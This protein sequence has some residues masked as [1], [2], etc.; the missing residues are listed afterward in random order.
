M[1]CETIRKDLAA[2]RDGELSRRARARVAAHIKGCASCAQEEALLDQVD[3]LLS[4]MIR[5]TPSP[6]FAE[7][8]WRRIEEEGQ[9]EEEAPLARWWRDFVESWRLVPALVAA[10]TL[11]VIVSYA[12]LSNRLGVPQVITPSAPAV[13]LSRK[14]VE[15]PDLFLQYRI[16]AEMD[17]LANFETILAQRDE[18]SPSE[19]VAEAPPSKLLEEPGLF[20]DY[21]LLR[22]MEELQN[23]EAVQSIPLGQE[24]TSR[25]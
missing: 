10:A 6:G 21:P 25:G 4:Q 1:T 17:K 12:V 13:G 8:F 9:V 3:R 18:E 24:E 7:T 11:L 23:F 2:Y 16:V 15:Q 19:L 14:L 22:R 20:V 5:L